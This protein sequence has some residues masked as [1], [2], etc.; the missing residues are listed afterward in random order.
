MSRRRKIGA[1]VAAVTWV[2]GTVL[3]AAPATATAY[4][5]S[6]FPIEVG[7]SY[8]IGTVTWYN[9]AVGVDGAFKAVGE[10]RVYAQAWAG[11]TWLDWES[12]STWTNRSGPASLP[13]TADVAGGST[14]VNVW[15]TSDD[16]YDGLEYFTC[17]PTNSVCSGPYVGKP[18]QVPPLDGPPIAARSGLNP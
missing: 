17:Y 9:R 18:P 16:P 7:A 8:Y 12:S 13:L 2:A 5:T 6:T 3:A 10:R 14:R 11:R 4:P 15:M 1:V